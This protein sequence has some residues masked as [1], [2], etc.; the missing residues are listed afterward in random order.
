MVCIDIN[1]QNALIAIVGIL[2]YNVL[3]PYMSTLGR[4]TYNWIRKK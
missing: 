1:S 3:E 4:K 2:I